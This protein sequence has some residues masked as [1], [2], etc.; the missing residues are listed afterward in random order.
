MEF[1]TG[2]SSTFGP[3]KMLA[4]GPCNYVSNIAYYHSVTKI[5]DYPEWSQ[6][7]LTKGYVKHLKQAF[8]SQASGSAFF[9]ASMTVV[10]LTF[11]NDLIAMIAYFGHQMLV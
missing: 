7:S 4:M 6:N 11:D 9:H 5:C 2:K 8:A 1:D 10:G 3:D